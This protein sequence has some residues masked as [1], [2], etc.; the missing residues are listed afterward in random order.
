MS[1]Q[2]FITSAQQISI[3]KPLCEEWMDSPVYYEEK[4]VRC[5]D[6]DFR[7]FI[8]AGEARRMGKLLKRALA[9]SLSALK[10]GSVEHPDAIITGTGF[11]SV[12]NTEQFL[13]AMVRQGEGLLKPTQFMQSTHN[14]TSSLIGIHTGSHGYNSTYSQKFLSFDSA[15]YDAWLQFRL[16]K[17]RTALVGGHDEMSEVFHGFIRKGGFICE[18]DICSEAAVSVLFDNDPGERKVLCALGGVSIMNNPGERKI[19]ESV[20]KL[21]ADNGL[22]IRDLGGVMTG[23]N[24]CA[25]EDA[26]YSWIDSSLPGIPE[27]RYK[28]IFGAGF[29]APALGVYAVCHCLSQ[30]FIPSVL[31]D[32]ATGSLDCGRAI[33]TV[34][35][36]ERRHCSLVLLKR[37]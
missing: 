14:T 5:V 36:D 37:V 8:S 2:I 28:H 3:Q 35:C 17:I 9:T 25:D 12:E 19:M 16:G 21:L 7:Q 29:S 4:F 32:G 23:M 20:A 26:A 34:N 11:G 27:L 10:E 22:D 13:D 30:G 31:V 6:P 1:S 18:K 33:L 15:L 24:G